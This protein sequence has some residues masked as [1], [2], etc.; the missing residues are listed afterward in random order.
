MISDVYNLREE[1]NDLI[2]DLLDDISPLRKKIDS[3]NV[4]IDKINQYQ[5]GDELVISGDIILHGTQT[6]KTLLLIYSG[7]I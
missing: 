1:T 3:L 6:V 7:R 5:H 4:E 2:S